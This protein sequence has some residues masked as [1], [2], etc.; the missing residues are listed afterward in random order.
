MIKE[1]EQ[2]FSD[3]LRELLFL[4]WSTEVFVCVCVCL[5]EFAC[6]INCVSREPVNS[7]TERISSH[8]WYLCICMLSDLCMSVYLRLFLVRVLC[9]RAFL[10]RLSNSFSL[11]FY[12]PNILSYVYVCA[13]YACLCTCLVYVIYNTCC[14]RSASI[15]F[16]T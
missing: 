16:H 5:K 8:I 11:N 14:Y 4:L 10:H 7:F 6:G 13:C 3:R 12:I 15:F 1:L 2:P 9:L